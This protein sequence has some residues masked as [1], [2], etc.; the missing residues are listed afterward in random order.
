[1]KVLRITALLALSIF[2]LRGEAA[3]SWPGGGSPMIQPVNRFLDV[4]INVTGLGSTPATLYL[5]DF[6]SD[7][8]MYN[9]ITKGLKNPANVGPDMTLPVTDGMASFQVWWGEPELNN[10]NNMYAEIFIDA[11][12]YM[13]ARFGEDP[14]FSVNLYRTDYETDYHTSEQVP[15]KY[16]YNVG[17]TVDYENGYVAPLHAGPDPLPTPEPTSGLLLLIG[18]SG[19]ARRRRNSDQRLQQQTIACL[20]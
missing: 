5:F 18:L 8:W 14:N 3:S 9:Y 16:Y 7:E 4:T 2:A 11:D 6:E 12:N 15:C 17:V 10:L 19:L 20:H 13:F 1:M